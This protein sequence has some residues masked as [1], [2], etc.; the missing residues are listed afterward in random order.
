MTTSGHYCIV[1]GSYHDFS[2][3]RRTVSGRKNVPGRYKSAATHRFV[4]QTFQ[5]YQ[6]RIVDFR[7]DRAG[8]AGYVRY[9]CLSW[10][11]CWLW[12]RGVTMP[13]CSSVIFAELPWTVIVA[14]HEFCHRLR[15]PTSVPIDKQESALDSRIT[16]LNCLCRQRCIC[17]VVPIAKDSILMPTA[18]AQQW[19]RP[20][21]R[22][23]RDSWAYRL[24][25]QE[26]RPSVADHK[27]ETRAET[28]RE[29]SSCI[30]QYHPF[31]LFITTRNLLSNWFTQ[32]KT[33]M[34]RLVIK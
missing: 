22:Q 4:R 25:T 20:V 24:C 27:L 9:Y 18:G 7:A 14:H 13:R 23:S 10:V 31:S 2:H 30:I 21:T 19:V 29:T 5:V 26:I 8:R 28:A 3:S 32:N 17:A 11:G 6:I 12:L 16:T 15:N 33:K 1:R 34:Q